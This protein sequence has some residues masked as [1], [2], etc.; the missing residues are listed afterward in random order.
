MGQAL[1][2]IGH[3]CGSRDALQVFEREDGTVDG[4]CYACKTYVR[5]PFGDDKKASDIPKKERIKKTRE[6]IEAEIKEIS[7]YGVVDLVDRKL[8]KDVLELYGI[9]IGVSEEDGKTPKFH[10]YPYYKNGELR[11]YK[12]RFVENKRMWTIGDQTDV[13]LFGWEVAKKS[14][15]RRLIITEGEL[16]AAALHKILEIYTPEQYKDNIPAV[17][18]LPHGASAA[19][20]DIAR[21]MPEIRK[22]FKEVSLAFDNDDAGQ[23]AVGDVCKIFPDATVINLPGKDAN[24]CLMSGKGKAAH[25]ACTFNHQKVKNTRLVFGEDLHEEARKPAAYG[26]LTWPWEHINKK[27]RGIRFGE[28]IY[29][30]AGVKM[31]KSELLNM[32]GAHFVKE[33][34]VKVFMAKPEEANAKTYKLMCGKIAKK[35][36]HDPEREFDFD[37]YDRAGEV[38]KDKLAMVNLYQHLGWE[39]L[40]AD[41]Y[42]AAAWGAKVVFIDPITNLT[43]GMA[44]ADA[45]VKL[46]EIAQEISAMA[47]DLNIVVFLFAHLKA[48]EGNLSLD[49]RQ[50][51]YKDG[52]FYGLGN[53][54]HELGGDVV[55][56]QFAGSRA[57]MRSCNLMLGLE[58]NKDPELPEHVRNLRNL[59][60][61]EDREF[62]GTGNYPLFWNKETTMFEE[63]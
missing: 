26:E 21:L 60:L 37:A 15:A 46:Q 18:S 50:K 1:V 20:K 13:D 14:G 9:K 6:E 45:N 10:Y 11:A 29:I 47:L 23:R 36:F 27:T 16:D 52:K 30:G 58:G 4:Y 49:Q 33:H 63:V 5:H 12:V 44:A 24:E 19:G 59:R 61:L 56:S 57:M 40:K 48:P 25:K 3:Q 22:Y 35:V 17:C 51:K 42:A 7:D 38:L 43:N 28:T 53:C 34:G 31:G 2:K 32:L 54:P 8:R 39:T 41:I 62:G 55:S